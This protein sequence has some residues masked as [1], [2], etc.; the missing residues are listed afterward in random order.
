[1]IKSFGHDVDLA[2]LLLYPADPRADRQNI[3]A[4]RIVALVEDGHGYGLIDK[5][6]VA[7]TSAS[8]SS[9]VTTAM[10]GSSSPLAFCGIAET[11]AASCCARGEA[12][13]SITACTCGNSS[14]CAGE[15]GDVDTG[16]ID[17]AY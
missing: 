13:A 7:V 6:S 11:E 8:S 1:M 3:E 16:E 10:R 17:K 9:A 5:A 12:L 15:G 4:R 2:L 14:V